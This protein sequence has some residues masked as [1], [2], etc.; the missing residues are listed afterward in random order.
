[1]K[2]IDASSFTAVLFYK[3]SLLTE[4]YTIL[5]PLIRGH[6]KFQNVIGKGNGSH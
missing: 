5:D 6:E 3:E 2:Q 1:M 4:E